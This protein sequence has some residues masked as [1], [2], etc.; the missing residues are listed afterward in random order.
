MV[1][2]LNQLGIATLN[3]MAAADIDQLIP[4]LG[5]VAA[6]VRLDVWRDFARAECGLDAA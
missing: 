3:D 5:A 1:H 6:L 4:K 2:R